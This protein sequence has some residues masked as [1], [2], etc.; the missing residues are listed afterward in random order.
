MTEYGHPI[1]QSSEY[2]VELWSCHPNL[3]S[4]DKSISSF[5]FGYI[6]LYSSKYNAVNR[7]WTVHYKRKNNFCQ[8][9]NATTICLKIGNS[10]SEH[11]TRGSDYNQNNSYFRHCNMIYNTVD[12]CFIIIWVEFV[13]VFIKIIKIN[14][15]PVSFL[16]GQQHY[17][18]YYR[19]GWTRCR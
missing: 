2:T 13:I 11:K 17:Y 5:L 14:Y 12:V 19:W 3:W 8:S 1:H 16:C 18:Y 7:I 10:Y 4:D 6:P 15:F 9:N